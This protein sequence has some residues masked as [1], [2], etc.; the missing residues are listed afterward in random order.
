MRDVL[1]PTE[2]EMIVKGGVEDVLRMKEGEYLFIYSKEGA[3]I[4]AAMKEIRGK[5]GTK[6]GRRHTLPVGLETGATSDLEEF[7]RSLRIKMLSEIKNPP[8]EI[9]EHPCN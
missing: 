4:P 8:P 2:V 9:S 3:I 6:Q 5:G 1:I 7:R